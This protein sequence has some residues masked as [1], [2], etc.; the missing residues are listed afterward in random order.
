MTSSPPSS[1]EHPEHPEHAEPTDPSALPEPSRTADLV[2]TGC[3]VL[4]HDAEE[5]VTFREDAAIVVRD[6]AVDQATS[7]AD[8]RPGRAARARR[9]DA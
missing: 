7:A 1:P 8:A 6:G 3:T 9:Y 2:I 4:A 5:R